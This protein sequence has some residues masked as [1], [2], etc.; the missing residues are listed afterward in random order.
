[1][2]GW[3]LPTGIGEECRLGVQQPASGLMPRIVSLVYRNRACSSNTRSDRR[4][5]RVF[6]S[7]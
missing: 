1:M 6:L 7:G 2:M 3:H 4:H 5:V